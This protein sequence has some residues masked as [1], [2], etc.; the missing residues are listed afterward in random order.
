ML[1]V[2]NLCSFTIYC[3]DSLYQ[4]NNTL[5]KYFLF[6]MFLFLKEKASYVQFQHDIDF[7]YNAEIEIKL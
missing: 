6:L 2:V 4:I 7:K 1:K 5:E 3:I